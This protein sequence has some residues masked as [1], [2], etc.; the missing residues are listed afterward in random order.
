MLEQVERRFDVSEI[1]SL[2][3]SMRVASPDR[4]QRGR[5]SL[6]DEGGPVTA[7]TIEDDVLDR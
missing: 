2:E 6:A 3:G 5:D 4:N 1:D 7:V